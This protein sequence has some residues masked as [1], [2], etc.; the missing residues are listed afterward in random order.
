MRYGRP[1]FAI[2]VVAVIAGLYFVTGAGHRAAAAPPA[3]A[4]SHVAVSTATRACA[5]PG[6][7]APTSASLALTAIPGAASAGTASISPLTPA[8]STSVQP[9]IATLT[10]PGV[11]SVTRI[12]TAPPL[13]KAQ[14]TGQP[15]S[16]PQLTTQAARGGVEINASG[17]MAQGIEAEQTGPGGLTTAQCG[18]P[19]TDFWFAG[20]GQAVGGNIDIYLMNTGDQAADAQVSVLTDVTNGPPLLA[21]ADSGITV[22]AH[23]IVVQSLTK[24]LKSSK[25]MA[26]NVTTSVGQVTAAVRE[27]RSASADGSWLPADQSPSQHVVI[28]GLPQAGS[29]RELYIAVPGKSSAQ[30]KVT[31]VTERGS[32]QPTG[33]T[34]IDLLGG[35]V[36]SIAL[37]SVGGIPGA[38][39]ITSTVPVVASMLVGGGPAGS[40][41][42]VAASA[43]P[44]V[45]QGVVANNPAHSAGTTQLVLS[46]PGKAARVR[47]STATAS[48]AATTQGTI[49][50]IKAGSSEVLP[51]SPQSDQ[52]ASAFS[53]VLT[54]LAGSGP[55]YAGRVV[56]LHG[57]VQSVL[58]VPSSLTSIV[59]PSVRSSLAAI[60]G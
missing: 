60:L 29:D 19:G 42:V 53:V 30:V 57:K 35:S 39:R 1:L 27:S 10:K 55:V 37:P 40:G 2:L 11:L 28:P 12:K 7:A 17:A 14:S 20:P 25:V 41:G 49:V 23:G 44:V 51:V 13:T 32:Y 56:S 46:A 50:T 18:S 36:A 9:A 31:A 16:S 48:A 5:A 59:L 34:G 45:Q 3:A 4:A 33:G 38:V 21:N 52:R 43:G 54:P 6:S 8:G 26:L 24:L 58:A 47:I 22:P 15:G